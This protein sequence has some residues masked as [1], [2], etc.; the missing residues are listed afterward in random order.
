VG[1][2]ENNPALVRPSNFQGKRRSRTPACKFN[3]T[4]EVSVSSFAANPKA[5]QEVDQEAKKPK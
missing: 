5:V 3:E 4:K 1:S 2:K